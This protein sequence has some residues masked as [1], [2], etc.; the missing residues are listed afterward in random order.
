MTE[1]EI[2]KR[3]Y[4]SVVTYAGDWR[5][6][7]AEVRNLGLKEISLFLTAAGY[8]ERKEI[9]QSLSQTKVKKIY[10]VHLRQDMRESEINFFVN[11]YGTKVFTTHYQYFLKYFKNS[12]HR[13][14]IFIEN[15]NG[16]ARI[17]NFKIF[18]NAGGVCIDLSHLE[19]FR[20]RC[21]KDYK[22]SQQLATQY[23]VGCNHLSA[24]LPN[25][26]SWHAVK[27]LS[28]LDYVKNIPQFYFSS[29]INLELVNSI[30]QQLRFKKYLAKILAQ[31]WKK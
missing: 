19:Y 13:A 8:L 22:L 9:Y 23:K 24:V 2:L 7:M 3:I 14:K 21:P 5:K 12:K 1:A 30:A 20:R 27:K 10:H 18:E 4:P 15:N 26:L 17:K 25:G 16:K 6:M 11:Q 28:D 29:Y 31:A